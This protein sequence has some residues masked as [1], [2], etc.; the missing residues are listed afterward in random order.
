MAFLI[1]L[2]SKLS[3]TDKQKVHFIHFNH[4]NPLLIEGST[5]QK[6][7]LKKGFN[8]AKEGQILNF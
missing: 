7:V 5:A 4:T 3:D 6:E 2:F 8:I 1:S